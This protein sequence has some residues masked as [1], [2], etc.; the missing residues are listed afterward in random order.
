MQ[1]CGGSCRTVAASVRAGG[2][3][4]TLPGPDLPQRFLEPAGMRWGT[5]VTADGARLRWGFLAAPL[6]A[7]HCVLV[8]GFSEFI[9]KYFETVADLA[10]RGLSVWCVDWRGQGA[11][12]RPRRRPDRPR[13]R[14]YDR[15]AEDLA[16]FA[17]SLAGEGRPLVV[18]GHSMGAAIALLAMRG[19]PRLFD[20]A[21]L[22]AP[23]LSLATG[24]IP[25]RLAHAIA[26]ATVRLGLGHALVPGTRTWPVATDVTPERS[27]TSG[28]ASRCRVQP[29]WFAARPQLRVDGVTYAWLCTAFDACRR[30][31]DPRVLA[32]IA[33]PILIGT[34]GVDHF[35]VPAAHH[36][37]AVLLPRCRHAVFEDAKHELFMERDAIRGRWFAEIDRFLHETGVRDARLRAR[38]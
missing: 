32:Q 35:V 31:D 3:P 20:A 10:D 15:D 25:V 27:R 7:I 8:G 18:V 28:D 1:G 37:A 23:M 33:T 24:R 13:A 38:L 14:D 9:E 36:R 6:P 26:A 2:R 30:L 5:Y 16:G 4:M 22:S 29:C 11:S 21:I 19:H 34:S 17:A 12:A